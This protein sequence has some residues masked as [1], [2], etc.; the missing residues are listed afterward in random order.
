MNR[1]SIDLIDDGLQPEPASMRP[2]FMNRGSGAPRRRHVR[3]HGA[4]M[5]PRFMNR[6]SDPRRGP[7][8]RRDDASMRPRFMNRGSLRRCSCGLHLLGHASMRPRFMNRGS[9]VDSASATPPCSG[10]N[11]APIHESGKSFLG[12]HSGPRAVRFNE[13]PIH[14]SGKLRKRSP[15][16]LAFV[17]SMRPRFMNRGSAKQIADEREAKSLQ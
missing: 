1:G 8:G 9:S 14:E 5:R 12:P 4:S 13:A 7:K 15:A 16:V 17:A 2:R 10:F 6:G 3:G 11:E